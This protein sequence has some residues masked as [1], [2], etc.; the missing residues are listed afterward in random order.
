[1]KPV[2]WLLLGLGCSPTVE[3]RCAN[4]M[5]RLCDHQFACG[6]VN[7]QR[8]CMLDYEELY[9]CDPEATQAQFAACTE[10]VESSTCDQ[11]QPEACGDLLCSAELGC[12]TTPPGCREAGAQTTDLPICHTGH[13]GGG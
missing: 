8:D 2:V 6:I 11:S 7:S 5:T 12:A 9:V 4:A 10:A 13:T 3:Q 1:M